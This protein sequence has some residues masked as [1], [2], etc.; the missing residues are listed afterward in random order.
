MDK[1]PQTL[2]RLALQRPMNDFIN[3][4][5]YQLKSLRSLRLRAYYQRIY[6]PDCSYEAPPGRIFQ[7]PPTSDPFEID[8]RQMPHLEELE[9]DGICNHIPI[10][11]LV[12]E[13]LRT[14]RLHRA[15]LTCSV[16]P[17]ESQRSH[18][19]ILIAAKLAPNLERLELD[20]G[21]IEKLWDTVAIPGVDVDVEQYA[22]INA[23]LKFRHLR[24]LRL[25]PPFAARS[26]PHDEWRNTHPLPVADYQAI[27]ISEHLLHECP[28][29]QL[30]SIAAIPS[31]T[32]TDTMFWEVKKLGARIL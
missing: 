6:H 11:N 30:L 18:K 20:I 23:L 10:E 7:D 24:F 12:G 5:T 26:S 28:S 17:A 27:R 22:F 9:I 31:F 3:M 15:D 29:L 13:T 1:S 4:I 2:Y 19:D 16:N 8:Y 32:R 25:F 14:L 21:Y